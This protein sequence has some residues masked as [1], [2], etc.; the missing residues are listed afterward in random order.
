M[1]AESR[2]VKENIRLHSVNS[3]DCVWVLSVW[4]GVII[5]IR[6]VFF[7][8][9]SQNH[10]TFRWNIWQSSLIYCFPWDDSY[11]CTIKATSVQKRTEPDLSKDHCLGSPDAVKRRSF[12]FSAHTIAPVKIGSPLAVRKDRVFTGTTIGNWKWLS[13]M[14]L[15][16]CCRWEDIQ[17]RPVRQHLQ[18]KGHAQRPHP[19]GA[20]RP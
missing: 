13:P 15:C 20:R 14:F 16:P 17:V 18:E 5:K 12:Y 10:L 7:F 1:E 8:F 6:H 3:W 2:G 11:R 9:F 19:G 4:S